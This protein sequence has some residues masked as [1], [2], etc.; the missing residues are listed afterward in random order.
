MT[1]TATQAPLSPALAA[2]VQAIRAAVTFCRVDEAHC[3]ASRARCWIRSPGQCMTATLDDREL[4]ALA[5]ALAD[6]L[7]FDAAMVR[8]WDSTRPRAPLRL[9]QP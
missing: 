7:S 1:I 2:A 6:G 5:A 8:A 4:L 3:Q 9:P